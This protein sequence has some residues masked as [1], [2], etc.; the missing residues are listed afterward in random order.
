LAQSKSDSSPAS[1]STSSTTTTTTT[2]T[3]SNIQS[4]ST[5]AVVLPAALAIMSPQAPLSQS[6]PV[7]LKSDGVDKRGSK[8]KGNDKKSFFGNRKI[9]D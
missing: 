9:Q 4:L 8:G 2:T 7:I 6:G 5:S 1:Y 3:T